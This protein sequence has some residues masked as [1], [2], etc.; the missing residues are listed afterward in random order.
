MMDGSM[1]ELS[2]RVLL[3][4][5]ALFFLIVLASASIGGDA[6]AQVQPDPRGRPPW[7]DTTGESGVYP[8]G[9]AVGVY[10]AVLDLLFVDGAEHP[11]IIVMHDTA[12]VRGGGPCPIACDRK[13][14]HK[15]KIDTATVLAFARLSPK[16]PKIIPFGYPIPIAFISYE[17]YNRLRDSMNLRL[18]RVGRT[19][20]L[21][22][23][24]FAA[25]FAKTYPGTWGKLTLSKVGFNK[26]HTEALVQASLWCGDQCYGDEILFLRRVSD[27]WAIVERIPNDAEGTMASAGMR[28][29]GPA[30]DNPAASEIVLSPA[31]A[32]AR[33]ANE[34]DDAAAVYRTVFDSLYNFHG[35]SPR[36][37]VISDFFPVD[38]AP[39][40]AHKGSIDPATLSRYMFLR[41]VRPPLDT[42]PGYRLPVSVLPRDSIQVLERLGGGALERQ[43]T[44]KGEWESSF[45]LAFRQRFPGAW[46]MLGYTRVAFNTA[47]SQALV[48]TNH[49]CGESCRNADT[50]LLERR[51]EN[52]HVV[53]RIPREKETDWHLDSL[54]YLGVDANPK[55]YRLRR[56]HGRFVAAQTGNPLRRLP[57]MVKRGERSYRMVTDLAGRYWVD[58]LPLLGPVEFRVDCPNPPL[59]KSMLVGGTLTHAGL[60]TTIDVTVDFGRCL[61]NRPARALAG[62][63]EVWP[64]AKRST[65]PDAEVAAVYR[66]VLDSLYPA[67]GSHKGPILLHPITSSFAEFPFEDAI[68]ALRIGN[69]MPRLERQGVFDAS[70]EKNIAKLRKDSVWLRPTFEYS[71]PVIVLQPL[72]KRFLYAQGDD[73]REVQPKRDIGLTTLAKQ[74]YPGADAILSFSRVAFNDAHTEALV[75]VSAGDDPGVARWGEIMALH[76]SGNDW[77]VVRRHVEIG[78]T[79]GERVGNQCLPTDAPTTVP[80]VEQLRTLV[81]FAD[82]T[83]NPTSNGMRRFSGSSLYKFTPVKSEPQFSGASLGLATVQFIDSTGKGKKPIGLLDFN[84]RSA[85]IAF[86]F[87]GPRRPN[88]LDG[89]SS[90]TEQFTILRVSGREFFG[91]WSSTPDGLMPFVGY[92]CGRLR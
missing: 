56:I 49:S 59:R 89:G 67:N 25:Q 57:V 38:P 83:V 29:R 76:K 78:K 7:V 74:A 70:M 64:D 35:E 54:R 86:F 58:S 43:A 31:A 36:Q 20:Y 65:Y 62:P 48:F 3:M 37:I 92:F 55:A 90:S 71:R 77:R 22:Q 84:G 72:Q 17:G 75:Q 50:W 80:T 5:R 33:R 82:I 44:E 24:E 69:E 47:R 81:G 60:D 21:E 1:I 45:W 13:W 85:Q 18:K 46:G 27:S 52:W 53:E 9:D 30:G 34:G 66:G 61:P 19:S 91:I 8:I 12:E 68:I 11:R 73:F 63:I 39:L 16:R 15:S 28:Y 40:P 26:P 6:A 14:P 2:P 42:K 88:Q 10:R 87:E 41:S 23:S 32:N 51:G 79:S 4:R